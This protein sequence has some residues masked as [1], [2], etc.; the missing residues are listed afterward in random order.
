M[1]LTARRGDET[2]G[3]CITIVSID[4]VGLKLVVYLSRG[5]YIYVSILFA[6]H[7]LSVDR[8]TCRRTSVKTRGCILLYA[9]PPDRTKTYSLPASD[10]V[11]FGED[12]RK[13]VLFLAVGNVR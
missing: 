3:K 9:Y 8:C 4:R 1:V 11:I 7:G 5:T 2:R 6:F 13:K 12:Y 10:W